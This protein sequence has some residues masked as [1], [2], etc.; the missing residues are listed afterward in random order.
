MTL[1]IL[2]KAIKMIEQAS[3][4]SGEEK[5]LIDSVLWSLIL[6]KS[7]QYT[8]E[9]FDFAEI[10]DMLCFLRDQLI[11]FVCVFR[12]IV[13]NKISKY[14]IMTLYIC[15]QFFLEFI[16]LFRIFHYIKNI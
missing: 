3:V 7:N 10:N 6:V 2:N 12:K 16:I 14:N 4:L 11:T 15:I 9:G 13:P 8:V 5:S 1:R